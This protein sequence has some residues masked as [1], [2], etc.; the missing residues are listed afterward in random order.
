MTSPNDEANGVSL[1]PAKF[2]Y[3]YNFRPVWS[4]P[5]DEYVVDVV[6][7]RE[8]P[9]V[10]IW[11]YINPRDRVRVANVLTDEGLAIFYISENDLSTR[12]SVAD[13]PIPYW[14]RAQLPDAVGPLKLVKWGGASRKVQLVAIQF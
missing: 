10:T 6:A 2:P 5:L 3:E 1:P 7:R 14:P 9:T 8:N 11:M 4:K 13:E 12:W